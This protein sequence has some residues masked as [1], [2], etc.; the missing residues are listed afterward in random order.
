MEE[1]AVIARVSFMLL[2]LRQH[3]RHRGP[4]SR[5][6]R[7]AQSLAEQGSAASPALGFGC[8]RKS[9]AQARQVWSHVRMQPLGIVACPTTGRAGAVN[10]RATA[11]TIALVR[12]SAMCRRNRLRNRLPAQCACPQPARRPLRLARGIVSRR[13][14]RGLAFSFSFNGQRLGKVHD[15]RRFGYLVPFTSLILRE[16]PAPLCICTVQ[17]RSAGPLAARESRAATC[18]QSERQWLAGRH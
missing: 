12:A 18:N 11:S 6:L 14:D 7:R 2:D 3:R 17:T 1:G 13:I 9:A 4:A 5:K 15:D 8:G 10:A 16:P